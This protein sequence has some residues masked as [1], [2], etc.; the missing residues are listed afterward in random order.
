MHCIGKLGS[1]RGRRRE[2]KRVTRKEQATGERGQGENF[3]VKCSKIFNL[4]IIL[5]LP[6]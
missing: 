2:D 6:K 5:I 4:Y 1:G 3:I